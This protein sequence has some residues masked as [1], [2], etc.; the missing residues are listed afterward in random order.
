MICFYLFVLTRIITNHNKTTSTRLWHASCHQVFSCFLLLASAGSPIL[1][2]NVNN[3]AISTFLYI[4]THSNASPN[5][6]HTP[7]LLIYL[8]SFQNLHTAG[9]FTIALLFTVQSSQEAI[10]RGQHFPHT[11]IFAIVILLQMNLPSLHPPR[12]QR[13]GSNTAVTLCTGQGVLENGKT[14]GLKMDGCIFPS[15]L[16]L[17]HATSATG[18][19]GAA[20]LGLCAAVRGKGL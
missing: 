18:L 16:Q 12:L 20:P 13:I 3:L 10:W 19:I 9:T 4:I 5:G 6:K 17:R 7:S 11:A 1:D 8:M 15:F 2:V 14:D